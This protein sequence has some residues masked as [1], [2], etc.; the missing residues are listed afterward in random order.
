MSEHYVEILTKD[1]KFAQQLSKSGWKFQTHDMPD[2]KPIQFP[3]YP[4]V[5]RGT[6][7]ATHHQ[8]KPLMKLMIRALQGRKGKSLFNAK[9]KKKKVRVI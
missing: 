5:P 3:S 7:I 9:V 4:N 8:A 1:P 2:E 6:P